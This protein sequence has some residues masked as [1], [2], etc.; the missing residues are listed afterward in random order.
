MHLLNRLHMP[1]P[2]VLALTVQ[3]GASIVEWFYACPTMK[4]IRELETSVRHWLVV[5]GFESHL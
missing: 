3:H 4:G 1:T 2:N 5:D